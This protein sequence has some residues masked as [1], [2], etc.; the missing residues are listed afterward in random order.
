VPVCTGETHKQVPRENG[1]TIQGDARDL[2][3]IDVTHGG[4][5]KVAHQSREGS[6]YGVLRAKN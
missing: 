1:S 2:H 5:T 6:G 4:E 3:V